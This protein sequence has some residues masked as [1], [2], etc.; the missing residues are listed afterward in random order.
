[1]LLH[2][3]LHAFSHGSNEQTR[4]N[5]HDP[6]F[7]STQIS[8]Q[9]QSHPVYCSFGGR[10]DCLALLSLL[11]CH[12]AHQ[13]YHSSLALHFRLG[14]HGLCCVFGHIEAADDVYLQCILKFLVVGYSFRSDNRARR[15]HTRAVDDR[16]DFAKGFYCVFEKSLDL[17][18]VSDIGFEEMGFGLFC[19]FLS[20]LLLEVSDD[21]LGA[22][23]D[24]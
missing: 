9:W 11:A 8:S 24:Q 10:V 20:L 3:L 19:D 14:R 22:D 7:K 2:L 13:N 5:R 6:Y 21:Y 23:R 18:L 17:F 1:M 16:I 15:C 12:T 4:S